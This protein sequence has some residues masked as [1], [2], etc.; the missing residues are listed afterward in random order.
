MGL[1]AASTHLC[2][3]FTISWLSEFD[4][5]LTA[6][7]ELSSKGNY[8]LASRL[9]RGEFLSG[10]H[11]PS[12]PWDE[13]V[14]ARRAEIQRTVIETL[15]KAARSPDIP[16]ETAVE[17]AFVAIKSDEF[18]EQAHRVYLRALATNKQRTTAV[19]HYKYLRHVLCRELGVAPEEATISLMREI[20]EE[21][22]SARKQVNPG[23]SEYADMVKLGRAM[24]AWVDNGGSLR[25]SDIRRAG[26]MMC[27]FGQ[28]MG[29]GSTAGDVAA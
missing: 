27:A 6:F 11:I 2:G 7:S 9:L 3:D 13:W 22:L 16:P 24:I 17:L 14:A 23:T 25:K 15:L 26:E 4:L 8:L 28:Q 20:L 1:E 5:D 21:D 12:D 19:V 10:F 18:N 29:T